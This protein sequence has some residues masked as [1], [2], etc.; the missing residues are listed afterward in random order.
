MKGSTID[1]HV[2]VVNIPVFKKCEKPI[3]AR[4]QNSVIE[5]KQH[6]NFFA[7][8]AVLSNNR[9][10]LQLGRNSSIPINSA[11]FT[12]VAFEI[13]QGISLKK[14]IRTHQKGK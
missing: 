13:Y 7:K 6:C 12:A 10:E 1:I 9:N 4:L 11:M 14:A 2:P 5:R 3:Q 8:C